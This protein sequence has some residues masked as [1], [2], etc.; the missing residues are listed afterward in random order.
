MKTICTKCR[1]FLVKKGFND[2]IWYNQFC[3]ANPLPEGFDYVAGETT[4]TATDDKFKYAR[5][6]NPCGDCK[7]Y[8]RILPPR[9]IKGRFRKLA[10]IQDITDLLSKFT[11]ENCFGLFGCE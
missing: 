2:H 5:D 6:C 8:K 7:K 1:N 4:P 10:T 9:D 3:K 11:L